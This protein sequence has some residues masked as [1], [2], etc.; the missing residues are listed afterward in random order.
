MGKR[1]VARQLGEG[2]VEQGRRVER[3]ARLPVGFGRAEPAVGRMSR[4]A[5]VERY[6][7][8]VTRG[9]VGRG[10]LDELRLCLEITGLE[11]AAPH[12][13]REPRAA[14]ERDERGRAIERN[15]LVARCLDPGVVR[16]GGV[17]RSEVEQEQRAPFGQ[18]RERGTLGERPFLELVIAGLERE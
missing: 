11:L 3:R 17:E 12:G 7:E 13:L 15:G 1:R 5:P 18:R 16:R 2:L 8:P 9:R 14:F 4:G 10:L 6:A